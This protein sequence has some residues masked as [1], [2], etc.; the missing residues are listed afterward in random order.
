MKQITLDGAKGKTIK[1]VLSDFDIILIVFEDDSYI[2]IEGE[3]AISTDIFDIDRFNR[4]DMIRLG[5]I[6]DPERQAI[7]DRERKEI[8]IAAGVVKHSAPLLYIHEYGLGCCPP[9][10]EY[11]KM[12]HDRAVCRGQCRR[13]I[14]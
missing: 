2:Y 4:A 11:I 5:F 3:G 9:D 10:C 12:L 1:E 7:L 6:H 8:E 14:D 13:K